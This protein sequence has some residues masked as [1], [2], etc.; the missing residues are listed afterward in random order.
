MTK[1]EDTYSV[2]TIVRIRKTG[3]F[4]I[5]R[6]RLFLKE[7]KK[8]FHYIGQ[9]EGTDRLRSLYHEDLELESLPSQ[10]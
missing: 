7:S 6:K 10:N 2:G 9:I 1:G 3:E 8:F 4:A 5:I